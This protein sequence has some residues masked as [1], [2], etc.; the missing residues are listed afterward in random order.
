MKGDIFRIS[1]FLVGLFI[2]R[3]KFYDGSWLNRS[4][5]YNAFK[6]RVCRLL[7]SSCKDLLEWDSY[8]VMK[9]G[10][11]GICWHHE[12]TR[13]RFTGLH[14]IKEVISPPGDIKNSHE[15]S[16]DRILSIHS[17]EKKDVEARSYSWKRPQ[18]SSGSYNVM[19]LAC[20]SVFS[21]RSFW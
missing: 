20:S 6:I 14:K 21:P 2:N 16:M 1:W 12:Y 13:L 4:G 8:G 19:A 9:G 3:Q 10:G 5:I 18:V 15:A 11:P 17:R 7:V